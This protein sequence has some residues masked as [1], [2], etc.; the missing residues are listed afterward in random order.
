MSELPPA[1]TPPSRPQR[2]EWN[3][4]RLAIVAAVIAAIVLAI[5]Y[6]RSSTERKK[7]LEIQQSCLRYQ[8]PANQVVYD[9]QPARA[10]ELLARGGEYIAISTTD[11]PPV[12][13]FVPQAWRDM[14][15]WVMPQETTPPRN[16]VLFLHE[17]ETYRGVRGLVCVEADRS[18]RELRITFIHP[19]GS[20][21][22]PVPITNVSVVPRPQEGLVL[23]IAPGDPFAE[24]L[25]PENDPPTA[26]A[27]LR[28]FAGVAD[29]KDPTHITLTYERDDERG[30]VDLWVAD[31]RTVH[32]V[33]HR[34]AG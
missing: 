31:E 24:R 20:M 33:H 32:F 13:G 18:A 14:R 12:A 23:L 9:E 6:R 1:T 5:L 11:G 8:A 10:A 22:D 28:F 17:R 15:K 21:L 25:P 34:Q 3:P 4:L 30:V 16:A 7:L 26:R 27:N 19:G 2:R 29:A